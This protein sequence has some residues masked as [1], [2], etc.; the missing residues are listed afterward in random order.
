M[1]SLFSSTLDKVAPLCLRNI[2]E[3]SPTPCIMST[4][5]ALKRGST[6][7]GAQLEETKLE[8]FRMAWREVPYPTE[9]IKNSL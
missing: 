8:V 7:N 6:E 1:D 9:S 2:K 4:P 5:D 3:K